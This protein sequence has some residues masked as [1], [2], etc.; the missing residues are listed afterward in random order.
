MLLK[1]FIPIAHGLNAIQQYRFMQDGAIPHRTNEVFEVLDEHFSVRVIGLGYPSKLDGGMDW[2]PYSPDLN[3]CDFFLW[4][5]LKDKIYRD[6]PQTLDQLKH[7]I[8]QE[9]AAIDRIVLK[10]VIR[11]FES[12]LHAVIEVEG[13]HIEQFLH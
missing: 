6:N 13:A 3:P 4:G 2:P 5:F 10:N 11:G 1:E 9:V 8:T 7:A 12:R